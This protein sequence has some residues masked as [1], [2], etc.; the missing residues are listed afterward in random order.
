VIP[1]EK[2]PTGTHAATSDGGANQQ[3]DDAEDAANE[4]Q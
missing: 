2:T 1:G 3:Q 4:P